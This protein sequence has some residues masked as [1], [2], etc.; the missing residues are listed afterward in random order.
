MTT[1]ADQGYVFATLDELEAAPTLAPGA[2]NDGRQRY[3]VRRRLEIT[4][5]GVQAFRAPEGVDVVREH[6]ENLL[7]EDGQ[8]ELYVVLNGA[9]TFEIDGETFEAPAGSLVQV[10]PAARRKATAK[11]DGTTIL[12][13]G[14]TPGK[15]YEPAPQEAADAFLAYNTGDFE[16]AIAKQRIVL[17]KRPNDAVAHFNA[18]CFAARAGLA[19]EA[20]EH[21]GRSLQINERVAELVATDEDLDSIREDGRFAALT[22]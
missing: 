3:D 14:G 22:T 18:G 4:S 20:F 10:R 5:F 17:E 16:T 19:D 8:E 6:T 21:L 13:V 1:T 9:A 15:A 2:P 7:G 12:V 11:D